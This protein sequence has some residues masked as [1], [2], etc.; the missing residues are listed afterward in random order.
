[1]ERTSKRPRGTDHIISQIATA[2]GYTAAVAA[3]V[4]VLYELY[5][6]RKSLKAMMNP[7]VQTL[8]PVQR[9]M[10]V[11]ESHKRNLSGNT[12]EEVVERAD[13]AMRKAQRET[14]KSHRRQT[15]RGRTTRKRAR[16]KR[17]S[18]GIGYVGGAVSVIVLGLLTAW[19][20]TKSWGNKPLTRDEKKKLLT[21]TQYLEEYEY[22]EAESDDD[23][24][25]GALRDASAEPKTGC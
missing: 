19:V 18:S 25:Q 8:T 10:F 20:V 7:R 14:A 4:A 15:K 3:T 22:K 13:E 17:S 1:M 6:K 9:E 11:K 5:R 23:E 16:R 2:F 12:P 21:K 24:L